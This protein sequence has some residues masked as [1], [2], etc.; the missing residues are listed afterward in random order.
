MVYET[1][2]SSAYDA[3]EAPPLDLFY[4]R[5]VNWGDQYLVWAEESDLSTC[6]PSAVDTELDGFCNEFDALEG[7]QI[8]ESGEAS[9]TTSPGGMYFHATWNQWD[10]DRM[11][12]E[13]T[14]ADAWYRR[15]LFLEGYIPE[16]TT[17]SSE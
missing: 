17:T 3:G 15:V 9:V 8:S 5:A 2:M 12:G 1:G 4:S 14:G 11:T 7:S 16:T 10:F 6:L 13:E